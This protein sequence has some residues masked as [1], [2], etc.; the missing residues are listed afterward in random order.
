MEIIGQLSDYSEPGYSFGYEQVSRIILRIS[1]I[2]LKN[3]IRQE[4]R[5]YQNSVFHRTKSFTKQ[6]YR[7]AIQH[8]HHYKP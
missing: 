1:R 4:N 8:R 6:V 2:I 7:H 3:L 5:R